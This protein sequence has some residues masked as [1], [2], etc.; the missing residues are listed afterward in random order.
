MNYPDLMRTRLFE[1][2]GMTDSS[3]QATP[4]VG[5]NASG[6]PVQPWPMTG[7][8]PAGA[9]ISTTHDLGLLATA[10]LKGTAPG[11]DALTPLHERD[12]TPRLQIGIFWHLNAWSDGRT[13]TWHDGQTGGFSSLLY[14]DRR[15]QRA[16]FLLSD[17]AASANDTG[18]RLLVG[19]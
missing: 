14:L 6:Q 18:N 3:A 13:V 12:N 4:M 7:Y 15:A 19:E 16:V 9:V 1:P 11:M 2:L 10:L 8:A 5:H 17:V